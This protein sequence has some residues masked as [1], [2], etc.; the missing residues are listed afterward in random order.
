MARIRSI[1]PAFFRHRELFLL[2]QSSGLP[3]RLGFAG[4]WTVSDREGRF[5]WKPEELKL[6][7]L[8]YDD[9]DFG[10]VLSALE[11][12]RFVVRYSAGGKDYGV[13]PSWSEHQVISPREAQSV[14]PQPSGSAVTSNCTREEEREREEEGKGTVSSSA[15]Q[16]ATEPEDTSP[17]AMVFPTVGPDG[18]EWRLRTKQLEEWQRLFPALDVL[19]EARKALAWVGAHRDRR[20]TRRGMPKFL[21]GWFTRSNDRR[22]ASVPTRAP[23]KPEQGRR[24]GQ[25]WTEVCAEL[26]GGACRN[27]WAHGERMRDERDRVAS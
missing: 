13:I 18:P 9:V 26:H 4:L 20:K 5:R 16:A 14:L 15:P 21:V 24:G 19:D 23:H 11:S 17:V 12:G 1:K 10:A 6:D 7:C 27:G 2:E 8:P 22:P 25:H 3:V